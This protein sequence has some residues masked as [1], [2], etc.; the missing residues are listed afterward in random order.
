MILF[1]L[2]VYCFLLGVASKKHGLYANVEAWQ[3]VVDENY[4]SNPLEIH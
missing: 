1:I 4:F 2:S 3:K